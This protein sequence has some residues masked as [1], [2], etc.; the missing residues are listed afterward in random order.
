MDLIQQLSVVF[1][2]LATLAVAL[3]WLKRRGAARFALRIPRSKSSRSLEAVERL[4]LGP[5]HSLHLIRAGDRALLIG[6]SPSGCALLES[7]WAACAGGNIDFRTRPGR[8]ARRRGADHRHTIESLTWTGT[9]HG[10][11]RVG[12]LEAS[13]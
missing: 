9:R 7:G 2:V 6:V 13:K 1:L 5:Q 8:F 10:N 3:W 4:P 11:V 12:R